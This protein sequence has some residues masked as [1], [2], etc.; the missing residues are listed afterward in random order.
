MMV[1]LTALQAAAPF[2]QG[3]DRQPIYSI[4]GIPGGSEWN[5]MNGWSGYSVGSWAMMI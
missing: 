5:C 1:E 3:L 2:R 4:S